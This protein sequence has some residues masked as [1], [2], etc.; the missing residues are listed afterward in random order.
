M[1]PAPRGARGQLRGPRRVAPGAA[2]LPRLGDG[3]LAAERRARLLLAHA[4]GRRGASAGRAD[5]RATSRRWS[6]PTTR[7]A[8]TGTPTTFRPTGS[9][10]P[11]SPSAGSRP[12][13][14]TRPW[15][16]RRSA[17][18]ATSWPRPASSRPA[19][20]EEN[21]DFG[22]PDE[23]IT[24]T[25]DCSAVAERKYASLAAHAS[26]SDNIFFL[27]MGEELFSTIMGSESF[28]PGRGLARTR[29]CP[30]TTC[31]PACADHGARA[32]PAPHRE[33]GTQ[34]RSGGVPTSRSR[35]GSSRGERREPIRRGTARRRRRAPTAAAPRWR[36]P[37][38]RRGPAT[39]P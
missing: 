28:V 19:E 6:S 10:T 4:G 34:A 7:T 2:R 14:T 38:W 39:N 25:V 26:Q 35:P 16:A 36:R 21:P 33:K 32:G 9:P 1:P 8:S 5:A 23:L 27:Q 18:S 29:R 22:T 17:A 3:G 31:S 13:C 20:V 11:P 30:R 15:R 12:S 37:P 24:T